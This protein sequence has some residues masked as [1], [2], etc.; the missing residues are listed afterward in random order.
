MFLYGLSGLV[1]GFIVGMAMNAYLLQGTPRDVYLR[2]KKLRMRYGLLNWAV[3]FLGLA[4]AL[5]VFDK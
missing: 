3:A 2:D 4:I 5:A 1:L